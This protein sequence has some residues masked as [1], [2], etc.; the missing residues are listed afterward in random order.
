MAR[1]IEAQLTPSK[2]SI[3][4]RN[5]RLDSLRGLAALCVLVHHAFHLSNAALV[6]RLLDPALPEIPAPDVLGRVIVAATNGGM[7]VHVFFVL[8]GA[9]LMGSLLREERF[10]LATAA[11]FTGRRVL[12]I[13]PA[14]VVAVVAF[15]VAS[16]LHLPSGYA[17]PFTAS[18]VFGNSLL[19]SRAVNGGTWTLQAE[20]LMVPVLLAVGWLRS[21][22]GLLAPATF[23]FWA[24]TTL[25]LG[26]PF[27]SPLLTMAFPAFALGMMVPTQIARDAFRPLPEWSWLLFLA[28]MVGARVYFSI[29]SVLGILIILFLAFCAITSLYHGKART[30]P[31][32]HPWLTFLGKVSYSLYLLHVM[33]IWELFPFF[34][35]LLGADR[36][37]EGYLLFGGLFALVAAAIT[38]PLSY[39][40]ERYVERPFICLGQHLFPKRVPGTA[41]SRLAAP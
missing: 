7:A 18:E 34:S 5:S 9:V 3:F 27:G 10:T 35:A 40:L 2:R 28:A 39:L 15:G 6:P 41:A 23:L 24:P 20:M 4:V 8:S 29:Q 25:I 13:Y 37:A 14:L 21:I 26:P 1:F 12:R 33:V 31:F 30:H 38:I 32:D 16:H 11:M 17:R 22:F 36:I 19:I